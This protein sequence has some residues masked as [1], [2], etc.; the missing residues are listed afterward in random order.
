MLRHSEVKTCSAML[1]ILA[2]ESFLGSTV[3]IKLGYLLCVEWFRG[4]QSC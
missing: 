1:E 3:G 4:L 2:L